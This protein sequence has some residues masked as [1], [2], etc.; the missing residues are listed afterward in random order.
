MQSL[1]D[2]ILK[3]IGAL[4][5]CLE[6]H[7]KMSGTKAPLPPPGRKE[8]GS[9]LASSDSTLQYFDT[10]TAARYLSLSASTLHKYRTLGGGPKYV[11]LGR[12]VRYQKVDLDAWVGQNRFEH[13]SAYQRKRASVI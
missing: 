8:P 3:A 7:R 5:L 9:S 13:T 11:K 6:V 12:N 4:E 2:A 10:N 1:E